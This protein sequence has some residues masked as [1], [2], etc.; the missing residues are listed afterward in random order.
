MYEKQLDIAVN[1]FAD[2]MWQASTYKILLNIYYIII[3]NI[4]YL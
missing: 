4:D 1:G 2:Y 3:M